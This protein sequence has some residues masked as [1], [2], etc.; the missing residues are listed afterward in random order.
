MSEL[1]KRVSCGVYVVGVAAGGQRN[2]FTAAWVMPVSFRPLLLALSVNPAHSSYG[3]MLAGR[4]FSVNVLAREHLPLAA[5]FGRGASEDK[6]AAVPWTP[7]LR[8][9][10]LL[11]EAVAQFQCELLS[12]QPAGD[13]VLVTG[14][15][16]GGA[17][18][19]PEAEVLAYRE[20]GDM[21]GASA[22]YPDDFG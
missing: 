15:V 4:A 20:T 14:R 5:H 13:H 10:P 18:L 6:L 2:A 9:V 16:A 7:G 21:D 19:R 11:N 22:V 8:G 17:L 1:F 12:A 3:L